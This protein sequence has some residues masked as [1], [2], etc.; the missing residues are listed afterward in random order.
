MST[1][2]FGQQ[3]GSQPRSA[4]DQLALE[5]EMVSLGGDRVD[6]LTNKQRQY[7]MQ[8]LSKWGEHLTAFGVE[9]VVTHLRTIRRRIE[10]GKAGRNF[11]LLT[12]L[13]LLPPQ[14][15]A[16][17][18]VRTVIDSISCNDTL[19]YVAMDVAEKLWIETMLRRASK[20]ELYSYKRVRSTKR[21]RM[22]S[23]M[24]MKNTEI[25]DAKQRMA[26][27]VLLVEMIARESGM[28]EIV[29]DRSYKPARR[30]VKASDECMR[31]ISDVTE[32][33]RLMTPN[34]LPM[35]VQ[36]RPWSTPL[37]GGYLSADLPV[38][39]FKSGADVVAA[40]SDG[41]EPFMTAANLHQTVGWKVNGW[42][43][44]QITH[45]YDSNLEVGCLLPRNG[46]PV[47]PFPKH[48]DPDD[49]GVLKW[50][51]KARRIHEKNDKTR[52]A[53]VAQAKCLWV[54]RRFASERAIYFPMSLDFRGRY[55][56]R[57][58]HL[59]PQGNDV[60]RSLLL[61]AEGTPISSEDEAD[62]LRIHGANM[63]GLSK[64]DFRA[65]IDWVHENQ[66]QIEAVGRD[67]WQHAEFWMR[68]DKPW[69]FLSFC[70]AYQQ[71]NHQGYGYVCDLPVMLDCTCSGI[72]HYSALLRNE[73]MG[74]LVNL[75]RSE[76]GPADIYRTV[77]EKVLAVLRSSDDPIASDWLLL[78]PDRTLAKPCVMTL[79]YSATRSAFYFY[80]FNWALDRS[81]ELFNSKCWVNLP[82]AIKRVH[83][84]ARILHEQATSL[85]QPAAEAM[86]WFRAVGRIAGKADVP[87]RWRSPS[88]LLVNQMYPNTREKRIRLNYLS[89]VRL[90]I[91]CQVEDLGLDTKRMGNALSPNVVHSLDSSHMTLATI[92][93]MTH[94]VRNL[95]GIH[96][97]FATTPAEM[98]QLR[99]SVRATFAQIYSDDLFCRITDELLQQIPP[100]L[101]PSVPT[102]PTLGRLDLSQVQQSDY[103]I[104]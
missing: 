78:Q 15:T 55:Y 41:T 12:P 87:L 31:W 90:D 27:G 75:T 48:L 33:Q 88:G 89:D 74:A 61:F 20:R 38:T 25:W 7:R 82:G 49:E 101:L 26:S 77:I 16:A 44:D 22:A 35:L 64:Q 51:K 73:E 100:D 21:Q 97:C 94:G 13:T 103:F 86:E 76:D 81:E 10:R 54:A 24:R 79:P 6:L 93:A 46:W 3:T 53:R 62:W 99:D 83:W 65:R 69:Q 95:G 29:L 34:W 72:Q 91:R 36:P 59:N 9:R 60:S 37:D 1:A 84:M 58:P 28:I 98:S 56:Y 96:D 8:S 39:L 4:E 57:P 67:P 66:L 2:F 42:M 68:A 80:A 18:A 71:F 104:T 50:R 47:P 14:V 52:N 43:L 102:R 32:Q 70:R 92:H 5:A 17:A 23:I 30:V 19:H 63:W 11:A 40:H 45:A 85:V